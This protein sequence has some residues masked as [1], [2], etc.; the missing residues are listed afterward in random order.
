MNSI[1][2]LFQLFAAV[3]GYKIFYIKRFTQLKL[4]I[5]YKISS[6]VLSPTVNPKTVKR[7]KGIADHMMPLGD[8]FSYN[9]YYS[10][11]ILLV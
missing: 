2:L 9:T 5:R 10:K 3:K 4:V 8:W 1:A 6:Y 11:V 7:G